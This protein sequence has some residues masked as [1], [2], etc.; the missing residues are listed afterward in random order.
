MLGMGNNGAGESRKRNERVALP[1]V[2]VLVWERGAQDAPR[3]RPSGCSF[4]FSFAPG[5]RA[6][7]ISRFPPFSS[8]HRS[9]F[10]SCGFFSVAFPRGGFSS[11]S[12]RWSIDRS[13]TPPA[14]GGWMDSIDRGRRCFLQSARG[15]VV[16]ESFNFVA[17]PRAP[18]ALFLVP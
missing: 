10:L 1:A 11:F 5:A 7:A 18:P 3:G 12:R 13:T 14:F 16:G 2:L 17:R 15:L 6:R 9:R 8:E 4:S